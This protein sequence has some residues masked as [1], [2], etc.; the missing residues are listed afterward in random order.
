[1]AVVLRVCTSRLRID[2]T[3]A[4]TIWFEREITY[5]K[6]ASRLETNRK[7]NKKNMCA[8]VIALDSAAAF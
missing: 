1:M 5:A 4:L 2:E 6:T 8:R 3:A 7:E